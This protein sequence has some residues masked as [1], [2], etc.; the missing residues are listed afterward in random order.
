MPKPAWNYAKAQEWSQVL[1]KQKV[2]RIETISWPCTCLECNGASVDEVPQCWK[3]GGTGETTPEPALSI[4]F[5]NGA[6]LLVRSEFA[7]AL[8]VKKA[9]KRKKKNGTRKG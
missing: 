8:F 2:L 6:E 4:I 5:E 1:L 7:A 3:C 9:V